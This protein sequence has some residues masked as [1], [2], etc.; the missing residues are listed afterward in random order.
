MG[1]HQ[2]EKT[3]S[4]PEM[5][6]HGPERNNARRNPL[7][8]AHHGDKTHTKTKNSSEDFSSEGVESSTELSNSKTSSHSQKK[9]KKRK[10]SKGRD[11]EEFKKSKPPTFDGEIKKGEEAEAWIL[12]LKKYFRVHNYSENLK[13]RITIFNLN[14]KASIWWE[15]LRNVKGIREKGLSW[16]KFE[17]YF[18]KKYLSEWYY[19]EKMKEFYELKLGQLTI[20]EYINKFLELMRYVPYIKDEKVKM[21]RFLSGMPQSFWNRIE[22]DEPK[23]L[24]DAIQK[25]RY[26]YEQLNHKEEPPKEWK[27]KNKIGF[28]KMGVKPSRF[29]N[30][31]KN[32]RMGFPTKS[33]NQQNFPSQGGDKTIGSAPGRTESTKKEPLKCWGCGEEHM[34]RDCPHRQP[35]NK[36]VY[37]IQEATT[38]DDVARKHT[39][40]PC[41]FGQ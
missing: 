12:G 2:P 1:K 9:G 31:G 23:T 14:G 3:Q 36:G 34:L 21:Q 13:S 27:K 11:P 15:D 10:Y 41:I 28:K 25:A 19:D 5:Q 8:K 20:D 32:P 16:N 6:R 29:K 17:K 24:E 26:C 35:N 37:N 38:V 30:F 22:F 18:K 40:N 39:K 33:V 7:K 4:L